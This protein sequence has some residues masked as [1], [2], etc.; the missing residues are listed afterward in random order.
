V[1]RA[2]GIAAVA[3]ASLTAAAAPAH[4]SFPGHNGR[5]AFTALDKHKREAIFTQFP[6]GSHLTRVHLGGHSPTWSRNGRRLLFVDGQGI[7]VVNADGSGYKHFDAPPNVGADDP[8]WAPDGRRVAFT[9]F[10]TDPASEENEI[11]D[12][13]VYVGPL[14]GPFKRIREGFDPSWSPDGRR[15]AYVR[16]GTCTGIWT[17]RPGGT[18]RR[19]VTGRT[20]EQCRVFGLAGSQPDWSPD[21]KHIA[22]TRPVKKAGNASERNFEV[23][24]VA[25]DGRGDTRITHTAKADEADPVYS[26][27][28][29]LLAY[30]SFGSPQ[31]TFYSGKRFRGDVLGVSWQAR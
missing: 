18:A 10:T 1:K 2:L 20:E 6:N 22:Y 29:Q 4:A 19:R 8:A 27:D 31:G 12:T 25:T 30:A 24:T 5:F 28:G 17:M 3:A 7:G 23:F 14:A 9:G 16:P 15:I 11:T 21:G 26:P 13:A